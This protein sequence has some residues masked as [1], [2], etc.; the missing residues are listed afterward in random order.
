MVLGAGNGLKG[1]IFS[2]AN[3]GSRPA[4]GGHRGASAGPSGG[5]LRG[6]PGAPGGR[7]GNLFHFFSQTPLRGSGGF[8]KLCTRSPPPRGR[9]SILEKRWCQER[10]PDG[11]SPDG[12]P[13]EGTRNT[14]KR[15]S[16]GPGP[17]GPGEKNKRFFS[18]SL[19]LAQNERW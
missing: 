13:P 15:C 5:R 12:D 19:I 8:D 7:S 4:G 11:R 14:R 10:G 16:C 18:E 2:S 6:R 1:L 3:F 17:R 9:D